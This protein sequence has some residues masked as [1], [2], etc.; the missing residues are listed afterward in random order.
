MSGNKPENARFGEY[1]SI[2][3]SG[4]KIDTSGR[5]KGTVLNE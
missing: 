1:N 5:T 2:D 4:N 3:S